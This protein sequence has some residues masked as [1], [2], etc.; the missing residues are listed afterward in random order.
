MQK[1]ENRLDEV[2]GG[3]QKSWGW[4]CGH[5][6]IFT[7][8]KFHRMMTHLRWSIEGPLS[9]S[10]HELNGSS[11]QWWWSEDWQHI[12]CAINSWHQPVITLL[13]RAVA[14]PSPF[15]L[16]KSM[17]MGELEAE[18][19]RTKMCFAGLQVRDRTTLLKIFMFYKCF[20]SRAQSE[21]TSTRYCILLKHY[22]YPTT[23]LVLIL[24]RTYY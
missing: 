19:S 2:L 3:R 15:P 24:V 18:I 9:S 5:C 11:N 21:C 14:L 16:Q 20:T 8:M 22:E 4:A 7:L 13:L 17:R 10:S 1:R 23:W 12:A 6:N